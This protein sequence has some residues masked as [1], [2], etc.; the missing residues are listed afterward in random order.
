MSFE[1]GGSRKEVRSVALSE[2]LQFRLSL[3]TNN[4]NSVCSA[5][6]HSS[7]GAYRVHESTK[8]SNAG[9]KGHDWSCM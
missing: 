2:L 1:L 6:M 9:K 3:I 4:E 7:H 5:G 8:A